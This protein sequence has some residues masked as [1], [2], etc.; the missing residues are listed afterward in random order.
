VWRDRVLV[1]SADGMLTAFALADGGERWRLR[2][3]PDV[4]R[5]AVYGQLGSRWP[6]LG[7]PLV[8]GDRAF[9]VAGLLDAI[10]GVV[11][12]GVDPADGRLLWERSEWG[13]AARQVSGAGQL[14]W[15]G[16]AV[17]Y[18]GGQSPLVRLDP[19]SGALLP[20]YAPVAAGH[21]LAGA[22]GG[23]MR[24]AKGQDVGV[25]PDGTVA[26]GGRRLFMDQ[27]E[28]NAWWSRPGYLPRDDDGRVR[29]PLLFQPTDIDG[30]IPAW[31]RDEVVLLTKSEKGAARL[32]RLPC[33][34]LHAAWP[35]APEA[36]AAGPDAPRTFAIPASAWIHDA[37]EC[38][39]FALAADAVVALEAVGGGR[40]HVSA[41]ARSDGAKSWSVVLPGPP[42][43]DGL[44]IAA[45]GRVVVALLD[46]SVVAVGRR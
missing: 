46:G 19:A 42:V 26:I 12:V 21:D 28:G 27:G 1:G 38:W 13:G 18:H 32:T 31:D 36:K 11:M 30:H 5:L 8:V 6:V 33:D 41:Y 16:S 22:I 20:A 3:A 34:L 17:I 10:D 29:I 39:G 44:A 40:C 43:H 7:S 2:V 45:D 4:G 14:C 9:A 25:L 35:D 23:V 15:D 37:R 24:C